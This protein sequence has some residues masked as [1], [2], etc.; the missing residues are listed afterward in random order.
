MAASVPG[1]GV[2]VGVPTYAGHA[3]CRPAFTSRLAQLG[4]AD[5]LD[6]LIAW[7]G[8]GLAGYDGYRVLRHRTET[9]GETGAGILARKQDALRQHALESGHSHLL[10]LESDIIPPVDV[11]DRLLGAD[12]SVTTALYFVTAREE[13]LTPV[14]GEQRLELASRGAPEVGSVLRIRERQVPCIYGLQRDDAG[15]K[16]VAHLWSMDDWLQ[17]RISG[18]RRVRI[19]RGGLGCVLIRRDV[20]ARVPFRLPPDSGSHFSDYYFYQDVFRAG[21]SATADLEC[22]ALHLHPASIDASHRQRW[23]TTRTGGG[24]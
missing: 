1:K 19:A 16:A 22:I 7:N 6:V 13:T 11:V 24:E 9:G 15:G 20:L 17:A 4:G 2:L 12:A 21:F 18:I 8:P 3:W 10:L 14:T 23:F 5:A